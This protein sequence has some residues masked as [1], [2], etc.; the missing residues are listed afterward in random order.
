MRRRGISLAA[1]A[2]HLETLAANVR[3]VA[4]DAVGE[5]LEVVPRG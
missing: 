5:S 3:I 1:V 2:R 4:P